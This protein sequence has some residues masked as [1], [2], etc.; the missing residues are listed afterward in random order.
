MRTYD[1]LMLVVLA[2]WWLW[3]R[4]KYDW[5]AVL[6]YYMVGVMLSDLICG[7]L[8]L[9]AYKRH[10]GVLAAPAL[11]MPIGGMVGLTFGASRNKLVKLALPSADAKEIDPISQAPR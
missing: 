4:K 3:F 5:K 7:V 1:L 6:F 9:V 8:I 10:P 2:A 11:L